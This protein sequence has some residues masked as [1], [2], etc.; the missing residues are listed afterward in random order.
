MFICGGPFVQFVPWI[1]GETIA[2]AGSA[3][4]VGYKVTAGFDVNGG[5]HMAGWLKDLCD[6][7]PSVSY[8]F[9]E[10]NWEIANSTITF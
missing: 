10:K 3:T 9:W 7:L 4:Q 6:G 5:V 1:K 2:S 8:T